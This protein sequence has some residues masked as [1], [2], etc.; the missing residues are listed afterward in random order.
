[1]AGLGRVDL[2][3]THHGYYD[4]HYLFAD[5]A[6]IGGGPA[7]LAAALSAAQG[8]AEVVLIDEDAELG[9]S[10]SYARFDVEARDAAASARRAATRSHGRAQH[11]RAEPRRSAPACSPTTGCR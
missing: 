8:G 7:G 3:P 10:L 5:V 11:P 4:K 2:R 6:V 1:M 9:G